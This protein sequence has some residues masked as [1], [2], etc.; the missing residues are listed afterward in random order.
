MKKKNTWVWI[1]VTLAIIGGLIA[2]LVVEGNKPGKY[3]DFAQCIT[4][5][6]AK[7][8]GAWW[9]P[10]C[11][12]QKALFGK[13]VKKLPYVECQTQDSKQTKE[14]DDVGIS[15]YPTWI[16]ADGTKETGEHTFAQL[17]EKTNCPAPT[18]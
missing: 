14:C 6:G 18:N 1:V 16:F 10:H 2:F 7:F 4:D 3:D 15:A 5:S 8:Y 17:S 11:A 9:C 12:A 13:S